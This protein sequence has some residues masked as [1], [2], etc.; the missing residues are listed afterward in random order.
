VNEASPRPRSPGELFRAFTVLAM[1]GFGGV[2]PI[3]QHELVE[4]RRWLTREEFA[5][6]LSVGQVLPGPNIVNVALMI[7]DRFFGWRGAMAAMTGIL[8]LPLVTVLALAALYA[9]VAAQPMAVGAMRGMGAAAAGLILAM[10]IKLAP[11]LKRNPLPLALCGAAALGTWV[12]VGLLRVPMAYAVLGFGG[13]LV[14][15]AWRGLGRR[16]S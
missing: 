6:L 16:R 15:L 14:A 2:L 4:K 8:A 9:Q 11:S 7:G 12:V 13:V 5:E 1:Q 3:A 10:G